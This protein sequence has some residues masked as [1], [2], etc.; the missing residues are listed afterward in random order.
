MDP[1]Q[2]Q[3][4]VY[5]LRDTIVSIVTNPKVS[6]SQVNM[7]STADRLQLKKWNDVIPVT[8]ETCVHHLIE[9]HFQERPSSLAVHAWDGD[10][11][12]GELDR[13]SL[14][15]AARLVDLGVHPEDFVGLLFEKSTWTAVAMLGVIRAGAAF[16]FL[17]PNSP[18]RRLKEI[19]TDTNTRVILSSVC[20]QDILKH[21]LVRIIPVGANVEDL[22]QREGAIIHF[23]VLPQNALYA[24]FTS[25]STGNPNGLV[26]E[27][28]SFSSIAKVI[29]GP[30]GINPGT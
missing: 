10:L 21:L 3:G 2:A 12:Y 14:K 20:H 28:Y 16:V 7:L 1:E 13:L 5:M 18:V 11:N 30:K 8:R 27:H 4:L 25:G 29:K 23:T 22:W 17:D 19:C 24:V 9:R 15:L 6:P 26:V